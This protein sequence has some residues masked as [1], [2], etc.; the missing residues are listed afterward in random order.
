MRFKLK[1]SVKIYNINRIN[2]IDNQVSIVINN[3]LIFN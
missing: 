2:F 1:W 3:D